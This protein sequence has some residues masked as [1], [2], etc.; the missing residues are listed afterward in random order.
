MKNKRLILKVSV[1]VTI[2]V[3]LVFAII[4]FIFSNFSMAKLFYS[5]LLVPTSVFLF[6][7]LIL[8]SLYAFMYK[9]YSNQNEKLKRILYTSLY[10]LIV[11]FLWVVIEIF[12]QQMNVFLWDIQLIKKIVFKSDMRMGLCCFVPFIFLISYFFD[13]KIQPDDCLIQ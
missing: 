11:I 9:K 5:L 4:V 10:S 6:P 7:I 12:E 3:S 8:T 1:V 13:K 2:I